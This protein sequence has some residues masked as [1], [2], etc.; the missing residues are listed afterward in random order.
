MGNIGDDITTTVPAV[1]SAGPGYATDI[2]SILGEVIARLEAK[3]PLSS[4]QTN[5]NLDLNGQSIDNINYLRFVNGVVTP[6]ASPTCRITVYNGD[7]WYVSPSATVRITNGGALNAAALGG[8]TGD[9]TGAGPMQFRYDSAN[10]RYDA[11]ANQG[12]NTWAYVRARGFD[13]AGSATSAFRQR[14]LWGGTANQTITWPSALPATTKVLQ[15]DTAGNLSYSNTISGLGY[16]E[17]KVTYATPLERA[18]YISGTGPARVIT[19]NVSGTVCA[20]LS[21]I[22]FEIPLRVGER[23]KSIAVYGTSTG[24]T[25]GY[26]L[27]QQRQTVTAS[28]SSSISG[29]FIGGPFSQTI[30]PTTP[31][32]M[33]T[34]FQ[35]STLMLRF[36][37]PAGAT[38]TVYSL[39]VVYDRLEA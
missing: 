15:I 13:I 33:D 3:I 23:L 18:I 34:T 35:D 26:T 25:T 37:P 19:G 5:S 22:Q 31:H 7:L 1:G 21:E 39:T 17:Y 4:L 11:F 14:H 20:A 16:G 36:T 8:I 32:T 30:T 24:T 2:N 27:Y 29:S 38:F 9:Y 10:T 12:A 6:A 28:I